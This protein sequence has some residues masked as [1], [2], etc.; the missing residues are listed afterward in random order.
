M[1]V[2]ELIEQRQPFWRELEQ[3]CE[4]L[5][6]KGKADTEA[7]TRF[8]TLYRAACADLALAESYQLP[9]NTV[10]YLHRLVA[11]AHNQMYRSRKFQ[12]RTWYKRIFEDTPKLIF[13]DPCVHIV[14]VVFWG[15]FLISAYLAYENSVWPGFANDVVGEENLDMFT[16]MYANFGDRNAGANSFMA[17]FY[18]FN[19]ASIGLSCFVMMLFVLPGMI[20]LTFNA[21]YLGT[22]FGYMFRPEL[23]DA[24]VN[25]KNFVTAHGPVELTAIVLAAGAGLKIGLSWLR[26][27][28]LKR[29]DS[30]IKTSRE[31]LPIVMCSVVLFCIAALIEGF[32]SPT[33]E[34]FLPWWVK[35]MVAVFT[36]CLLMV[37]FV[38]LGY[39]RPGDAE[40]LEIHDET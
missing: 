37:Y 8:A 3:L 13:N 38:V 22:V 28:G 1:K 36:S 27:G 40:L 10:D 7:V 17:G 12:W 24:S 2:A 29:T 11:K 21:V 19:N 18:V 26:T 15:L 5:A 33:S 35:G 30:L 34:T 23:G 32:V 39:P 9:R 20:T 31:A 4:Q 25:F 16:E 6:S 14:T